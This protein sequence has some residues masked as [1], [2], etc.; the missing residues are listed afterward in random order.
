MSIDEVNNTGNLS[1][2]D[3]HRVLVVRPRS[4]CS[5]SRHP[6]RWWRDESRAEW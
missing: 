2:I 5:S 4:R 1:H 3:F 6:G